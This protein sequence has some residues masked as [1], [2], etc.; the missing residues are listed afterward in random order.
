M[1]EV[2]SLMDYLALLAKYLLINFVPKKMIETPSAN[3]T[4]HI[5]IHQYLF[6]ALSK[7]ILSEYPSV[8]N[9]VVQLA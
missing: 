1:E 4:V 3:Q 6:A 2:F 9:P 7:N 8:P 5:K